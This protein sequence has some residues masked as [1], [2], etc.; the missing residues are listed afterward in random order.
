MFASPI[1]SVSAVK[2]VERQPDECNHK[3]FFQKQ[4]LSRSTL[5]LVFGFLLFQS[6]KSR[7]T[8]HGCFK[9]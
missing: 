3:L 6:E 9:K 8:F 7:E 1:E 4:M 5:F 2:K